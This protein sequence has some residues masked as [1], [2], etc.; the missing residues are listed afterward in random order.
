MEKIKKI[1]YLNYVR[2]RIVYMYL[3]NNTCA[4]E[5][6]SLNL[7]FTLMNWGIRFK[8]KHEI[9]MQKETVGIHILKSSMA[10]TMKYWSSLWVI[11][12]FI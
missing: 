8:L 1:H 6:K 2:K 10:H 3:Y 9:T 4:L 5:K 12:T 11:R 7:S